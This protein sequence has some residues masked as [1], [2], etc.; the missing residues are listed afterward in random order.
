MLILANTN[1]IPTSERNK[2]RTENVMESCLL[3]LKCPLFSKYNRIDG[4]ER[5]MKG[6]RKHHERNSLD[7]IA[8]G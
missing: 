8:M 4:M 7:V 5:L 2:M 1:R 6:K 3:S